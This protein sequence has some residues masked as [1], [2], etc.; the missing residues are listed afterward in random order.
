MVNKNIDIYDEK[1]FIINGLEWLT[2][3]I[4]YREGLDKE[5]QEKAALYA[6]TQ[7]RLIS[8]TRQFI[9]ESEEN[10]QWLHDYL[11]KKPNILPEL[12]I[13]FYKIWSQQYRLIHPVKIS[14]IE[15]MDIY[16]NKHIKDI[17]DNTDKV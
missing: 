15:W 3:M 6:T 12:G 17:V 11:L 5:M 16:G 14:Q 13:M 10:L 1:E 4:A 2:N 9:V 8:R 7:L